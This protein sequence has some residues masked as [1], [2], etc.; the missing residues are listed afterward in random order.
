MNYKDGS[1][2]DSCRR[3]KADEDKTVKHNSRG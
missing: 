3:V 2:L 1:F